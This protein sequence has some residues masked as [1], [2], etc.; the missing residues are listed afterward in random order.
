MSAAKAQE[1][2]TSLLARD[3]PTLVFAVQGGVFAE[4][5]DYPGDMIIGAIVVGPGLPNYNFERE[6]I[7]QYYDTRY[8]SGFDFAY[9]YPAMA[10]VIQ[11]AGRVIRSDKDRGLIV[12]MDQR[13]IEKQYALAMP[14][15]WFEKNASELVS[16]S[17]IQ[18]IQKFWHGTTIS[19]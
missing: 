7:R 9:V 10:K 4:G 6:Q 13:F 16:R 2:L 14:S 12:L 17:I 18:D 1:V 11:A 19:V 3:K 15:D 8:G 5:V